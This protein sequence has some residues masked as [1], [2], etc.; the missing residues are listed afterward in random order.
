MMA[1]DAE[2]LHN[3]RFVIGGAVPKGGALK[4]ARSDCAGQCGGPSVSGAA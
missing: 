1:S 3:E 2:L 4:L